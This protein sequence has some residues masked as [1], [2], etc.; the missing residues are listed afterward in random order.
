M[1]GKNDIS[2][3][4][5]DQMSIW[6]LAAQNYRALKKA[7]TRTMDVNGLS[8][9]VQYN[10]C[11][12]SSS[13]CTEDPEE[14][15]S[16]KCALCQENRPVLQQ[17]LPFEGRKGR[18][19]DILLNP[20]PIFP[21]HLVV[22]AEEHM[23]QSIWKSYV[24]VCD[25]AHH[26]TD[27]VFF[28]NGPR[29]GASIPEHLHFQACPRGLMPLENDVDSI[30]DI[31]S[32]QPSDGGVPNGEETPKVPQSLVADIQY[33][34]SVQE[35]QLFHYKRFS[36][37]IF[38]LRARTSKSLAKLFYRL[39]DCAPLEEGESEPKLNF[40]TWYKS[41]DEG[42]SRPLG[43]THGLANFEYRA[44]V[45]LRASHRSRHYFSTG[46]DNLAMSPGCADMAGLFIAPREED[47]KKLTPALLEEMVDDVA[48]S[49]QAEKDIIWRLTRTQPTIQVGIMNAPEIGFEILSD[50]AG[51]QK[52]EYKEGKISYNGALYD[53]LFFEAQTP[54]SMFASPTFV[55]HNVKIGIGFHWEREQEQTFAGA[56][57]F[58]VHDGGVQAINVI[59]VEDY[60]LSVIGSEMSPSSSLEL[61]KA[62][63][64]ISRSWVMSQVSSRADAHVDVPD[65]VDSVPSL[66]THLSSEV[67]PSLEEAP[68]EGD[69]QFIRWFDHDDHTAFD[70]CADDHCQR[71][72]GLSMAVGTNIRQ[73]IDQTWGLI[74]SYDRKICDCRFYKCC[75]GVTEKFSTCWEDIDHPYLQA[76]PDTPD[77]DPDGKC[78]CDIDDE[79]ILGQVLNG[80]D[81]ETK[82]FFRWKVEYTRDEIS[83]IVRRRSGVDFGTIRDL[84]PIERGPSG[85]IS[86]LKIVG[87]RKTLV[88]GKELIIRR[89]LSES[90]L[91]SSNFT[92][93]WTPDDRLILEGK[94]WG[95][96]VGLCQI[97]AAV[98]SCRG[99]T[100]TQIL[101]HY[102]PGAKLFSI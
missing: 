46:D 22:V 25:L 48:V 36:R 72:H 94:G 95:H 14:I 20:Y 59:G 23:P 61:L 55:L 15:R 44:I 65:G 2:K 73:A 57:R 86:K 68:E 47:F 77:H 27:Y 4:A 60:L 42:A 89:Y 35:A 53:E 96:G 76:L 38:I 39:V 18:K 17:P 29:A 63:A 90:H 1:K 49:P 21:R 12:I 8:V 28:Y 102:Y 41:F 32:S 70:V 52:V 74:L 13:T 100:Y 6:P 24:D 84:V 64:V 99:Y 40:L 71:Y 45:C 98:M 50:G 79:N 82:D 31:L 9:K 66:V 85:R 30:L 62:H 88:I 37:G 11:R 34:T 43:N 101:S 75:G 93:E 10:P 92:I 91:K 26:F 19:Y 56:L 78:F 7:Q 69:A 16:R 83:D 58:I 5:K 51:L 97:G 81:L 67:M 3:F 54:S 33:I 87:E 80:Y